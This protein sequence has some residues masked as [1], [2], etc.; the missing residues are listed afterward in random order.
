MHVIQKKMEH[1]CILGFYQ[2]QII[3]MVNV[4]HVVLIEVVQL[5][6]NQ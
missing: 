6:E 1:I 5:G 3:Q 2:D 4:C